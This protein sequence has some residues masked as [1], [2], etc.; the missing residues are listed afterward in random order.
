MRVTG[1]SSASFGL[2]FLTALF[3]LATPAR[4]QSGT[5][6]GVVRD[7]AGGLLPEVTV[8]LRTEA[9]SSRQTTTDAHGAYRFDNLAAGLTRISFALANFATA[10]RRVT[11]TSAGPVRVDV[12]LQ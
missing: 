8:Q 12:T 9:T 5:I 7:Q 4:C 2:A 10:E 6:I 11:V 1:R 3:A